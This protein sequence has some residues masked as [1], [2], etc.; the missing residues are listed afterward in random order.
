MLSLCLLFLIISPTLAADDTLASLYVKAS[1]YYQLAVQVGAVIGLLV[2]LSGGI[3]IMLSAGNA[4]KVTEGKKMIMGAFIGIFILAG[5][6]VIITVINPQ[7]LKPGEEEAV[8]VEDD[9]TLAGVYLVDPV[10]GKELLMKNS[11]TSLGYFGMDQK[12]E[13]YHFVQPENSEEKYAAIFFSD[14]DF[15]GECVYGGQ[16]ATQVGSLPF[17]PRSVYVF[18]TKGSGGSSVTVYNND[19]GECMDL[20]DIGES[21]YP[22]EWTI[23]AYGQAQKLYDKDHWI[24]SP[25]IKIDDREVLVL[26][27][28]RNKEKCLEDRENSEKGE[29]DDGEVL[30]CYHCQLIRKVAENENCFLA[31]YDYVY[32]PDSVDTIKPGWITLFHRVRT[33]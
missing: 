22:E 32:N 24:E 11:M 28:T 6:Y 7:I 18:K 30:S 20:P 3:K 23:S 9:R 2:I 1:D 16:D 8:V 25:S 19:N 27:E 5:S 26:L 4:S 13:S 14:A 21:F 29:E 33:D 31:K 17:K 15:R 10:T 12:G